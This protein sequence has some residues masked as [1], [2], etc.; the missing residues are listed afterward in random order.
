MPR[1]IALLLLLTLTACTSALSGS[2]AKAPQ[3]TKNRPSTTKSTTTTAPSAIDGTNLDTCLDG[4]CQVLVTAPAAIPLDGQDG[5]TT[6]TV[7][8]IENDVVHYTT[9]SPRGQGSG[10]LV[11]NCAVAISR[12]GSG[13]YCGPPGLAPS[14]MS[15]L[16]IRPVMIG[17]D[18]AVLDLSRAS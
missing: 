3:S 2:P 10:T 14:T 16:T 15:G 9:V 7:Q 6:F 12:T 4:T 18:H 5:L 8:K 11:S 13:S 17:D 1:I